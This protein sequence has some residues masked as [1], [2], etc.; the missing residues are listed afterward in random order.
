MAQCLIK[1]RRHAPRPAAGKQASF[2]PWQR[3]A[4]ALSLRPMKFF[5]LILLIVLALFQAGCALPP[6][7]EEQAREETQRAQVEKRSDAF[8]K[9]L[10]Q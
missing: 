2:I 3:C 5:A 10:Q 6:T 1:R 4:S 7:N 9:Q 8:A